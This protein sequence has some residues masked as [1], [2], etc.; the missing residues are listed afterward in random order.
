MID[1][2]NALEDWAGG[3]LNKLQP[4]E[5]RHITRAVAIDLRRSNQQRIASQRNPNGSP[6]EPRKPQKNLRGKAGRIRRKMFTKL[7]TARHLKT[8]AN[9]NSAGIAFVGRVNRIARVHHW[10][11]RDQV[12]D[13]GLTVQYPERRLLGFS[14]DDREH[15]R[16]LLIQHLTS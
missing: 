13:N 16:D 4:A 10:G 1:D 8:Q 12:N 7:R 11:L 5:R 9:A 14:E 15:I 2:L 6:F 3:L